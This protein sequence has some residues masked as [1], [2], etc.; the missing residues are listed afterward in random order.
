MGDGPPGD[1]DADAK[2]KFG[3]RLRSL[4]RAAGLTQERLGELA[5]LH[6]TFITHMEKGETSP[7]LVT[8]LRLARGLGVRPGALLDDL[9]DQP[10]RP[11][12][13]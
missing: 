8:I 6:R 12:P 5:G 4:R 9:V 2:R 1:A 13:T 7:T 10:T 11:A 3:R